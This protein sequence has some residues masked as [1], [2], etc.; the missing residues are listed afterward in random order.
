MPDPTVVDP[1]DLRIKWNA[2]SSVRSLNFPGLRRAERLIKDVSKTTSVQLNPNHAEAITELIE[3]LSAIQTNGKSAYAAWQG[4]F[5]ILDSESTTAKVFAKAK[6]FSAYKAMV[7]ESGQTEPRVLEI[8]RRLGT[9]SIQT[10]VK[11]LQDEQ[12]PMTVPVVRRY[13]NGLVQ[14]GKLE[15]QEA[16]LTRESRRKTRLYKIADQSKDT[17]PDESLPA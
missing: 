12:R 3:R 14:S 10:V 5:K 16:Y 15:S 13:L 17:D 6:R 7:E 2:A 4:A 8:V 11:Q 1:H 9:A